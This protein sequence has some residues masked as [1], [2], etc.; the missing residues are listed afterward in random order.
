LLLIALL[1]LVTES[2]IAQRTKMAKIVG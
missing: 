1:L 2:I